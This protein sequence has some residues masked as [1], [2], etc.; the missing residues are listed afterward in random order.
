MG[1]AKLVGTG[2]R[3]VDWTTEVVL[4]R[5]DEGNV[6]K[7]VRAGEPV[8]LSAEEQKGLEERGFVFEDS[9]KKEADEFEER[10]AQ[11]PA[12]DTTGTGP[13]FG[14]EVDQVDQNVESPRGSREK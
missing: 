11:R 9:S 1:Y 10:E 6:T 5:D 7:A 14:G 2:N 3:H 13:V 8:E 4:E 12:T